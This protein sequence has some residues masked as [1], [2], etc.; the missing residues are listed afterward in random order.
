GGYYQKGFSKHGPLTNPYA[1]GYFAP[2]R[3][4][5][6]PRFSHTFTVY[7]GG[8]LPERYRGKLLAASPMQS[9]L[10]LSDLFP[11]RSS[12]QTRDVAAPVTSDDPWFRPVD[13]KIG[14]D[15]AVYVADWYDGQINHYRNHEGQLDTNT[16][17]VYRLKAKGACPRRIPD[18][19]KFS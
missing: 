7:E 2:M 18:L 16:G 9:R 11:D 17:R 13:V 12:L 15:G 5:E 14:P 10:V 3:H 6:A 8:A 4:P 19:A 1:F